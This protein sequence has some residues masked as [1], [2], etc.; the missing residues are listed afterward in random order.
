MERYDVGGWIRQSGLTKARVSA[1]SGVS[2]SSIHRIQHGQT[3]PQLGT[4]RELAIACGLELQILTR[5]LADPG[6]AQSARYLLEEGFTPHSE[7]DTVQ[8]SERFQRAGLQDP[9]DILR[10]AGQASGLLSLQKPSVYLRGEVGTLRLA[11]AGEASGTR[12]ALSGKPHLELGVGSDLR[13]PQ[14]LWTD[15]PTLVGSLLADSLAEARSASTASVIVAEATEA[16]F[17]N[18][19]TV[20]RV[21]YVAPIQALIDGFSLGGQLADAARDIAEGWS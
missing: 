6:A 8:W 15:K 12:W 21:N 19:F 5:P 7:S 9:I 17:H 11:S 4:L 2:V 3:D 1:L 14:V 20:E 13:G 10:F 18:S 16:L